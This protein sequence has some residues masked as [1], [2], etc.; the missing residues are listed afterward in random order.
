MTDFERAATT[1]P[2]DTV[3]DPTAAWAAVYEAH[4]AELVRFATLLVGRDDAPDVV[5]S[6]FS[7]T[8]SASGWDRVT[9]QRAYLFRA[10]ANEALNLSRGRTRRERR[11]ARV[12]RMRDFTSLPASDT[13]LE[14]RR[15][16][17]ELSDRQ[18]AVVFLVYWA[19]L[20]EADIAS[21]LGI[22]TGSVRR[23]LARA[24]AH[25]RRTLHA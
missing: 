6:M 12:H 8:I 16:V 10:V 4:A 15:A 1:E 9:N 5:S 7:R 25:L 3:V 13:P 23:H 17:A 18:R 2:T 14:V 19:D 21:A 11:E 20:S 24:K 22:S